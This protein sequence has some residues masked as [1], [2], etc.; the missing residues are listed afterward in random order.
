MKTILQKLDMKLG[1]SVDVCVTILFHPLHIHGKVL[2]WNIASHVIDYIS[3][4]MIFNGGI[5]GHS[6][7]SVRD[8]STCFVGT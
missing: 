3:Y 7:F 2:N 4:A 5:K 6:G 1:V 8:L